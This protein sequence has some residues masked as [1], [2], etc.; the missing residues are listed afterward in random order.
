[1]VGDHYIIIR[2]DYIVT[3][4]SIMTATSW[5]IEVLKK[6]KIGTFLR[7]KVF[8]SIKKIHKLVN[9]N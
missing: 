4:I 1:M 3:P 9:H 8:H 7:L 6:C 2:K 5:A